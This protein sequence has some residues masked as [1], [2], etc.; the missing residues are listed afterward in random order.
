MDV[1]VGIDPGPGS[2]GTLFCGEFTYFQPLLGKVYSGAVLLPSDVVGCCQLRRV[3]EVPQGPQAKAAR[4]ARPRHD[5][6]YISLV[7][8]GFLFYKIYPSSTV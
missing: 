3:L 4:T 5:S 7:L 8:R 2:V 1:L 6:P